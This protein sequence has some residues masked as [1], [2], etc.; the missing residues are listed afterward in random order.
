MQ[1]ERTLEK[2]GTL[3]P[4]TICQSQILIYCIVFSEASSNIYRSNQFLQQEQE[5]C[6]KNFPYG[7]DQKLT[8]QG[9]TNC[10]HGLP[11]KPVIVQPSLKIFMNLLI[12]GPHQD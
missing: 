10:F 12:L 1:F 3:W 7:T 5:C 11:P 4:L 8:C 2:R 6:Y 9:Q